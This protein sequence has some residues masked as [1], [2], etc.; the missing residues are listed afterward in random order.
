MIK[1]KPFLLCS[2]ILIW[3]EKS[4]YCN[5]FYLTE[6]ASSLLFMGQWSLCISST[7]QMVADI[8]CLLSS[9]LWLP[10]SINK[11]GMKSNRMKRKEALSFGS[12]S[13]CHQNFG[14]VS[15]TGI[16]LHSKELLTYT[17]NKKALCTLFYIFLL[18]CSII[19]LLPELLLL[20]IK[21]SLKLVYAK[22]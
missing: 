8:C 15:T 9:S 17:D 2:N 3:V 22:Y 11:H 12:S 18:L 4:K 13:Y 5:P 6:M 16:T 10:L 19:D 7:F 1:Q 21:K 14:C 20:N